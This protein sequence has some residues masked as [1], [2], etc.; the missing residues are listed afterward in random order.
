MLT[1][2]GKTLNGAHKKKYF[3]PAATMVMALSASSSLPTPKA[4][5]GETLPC[6]SRWRTSPS[7][8]TAEVWDFA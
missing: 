1:N 7:A 5:D 2:A 3:S 8:A 6:G 4:A